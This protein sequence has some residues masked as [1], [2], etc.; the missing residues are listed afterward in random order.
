MMIT[1]AALEDVDYASGR[2]PLP[3]RHPEFTSYQDTGC[4]LYSSCLACPLEWCIY[5]KTPAAI[6]REAKY[7]EISTLHT[8]GMTNSDIARTIGMSRRNVIRIV[9]KVA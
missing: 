2:A 3:D 4:H 9:K 1:S 5:D 6:A 7:E 8:A